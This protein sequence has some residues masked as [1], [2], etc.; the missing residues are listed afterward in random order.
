MKNCNSKYFLNYCPDDG[1]FRP[2]HVYVV[3]NKYCAFVG[4]TLL[5]IESEMLEADLDLFIFTAESSGSFLWPR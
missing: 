2:K 4:I 1:L 3:F 5:F